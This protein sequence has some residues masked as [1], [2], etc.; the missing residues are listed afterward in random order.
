[1]KKS[2]KIYW[3]VIQ[4]IL[5]L[6][7]DEVGG[8]QAW[9]LCLLGVEGLGGRWLRKKREKYSR[10][11]EGLYKHRH[12]RLL[13]C[14]LTSQA[15]DFLRQCHNL[16]LWLRGWRGSTLPS[17]GISHPQIISPW[18][19]P[20]SLVQCLCDDVKPCILRGIHKLNRRVRGKLGDGLLKHRLTLLHHGPLWKKN[21]Y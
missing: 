19:P 9:L 5:L 11:T 15:S 4:R 3:N 10:W 20:E 16:N 7:G 21:D 8:Q 2:R 17:P 6:V 14:Q 13:R 18:P 1:M 12:L